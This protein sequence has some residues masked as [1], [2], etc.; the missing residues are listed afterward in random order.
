MNPRI[1]SAC[2]TV[3]GAVWAVAATPASAKATARRLL[4]RDGER[5]RRWRCVYWPPFPP[6]PTPS[7]HPHPP[8]HP[9]PPIPHPSQPP[10]GSVTHLDLDPAE[11]VA[12]ST[13]EAHSVGALAREVRGAWRPSEFI[14][15][16][17]SCGPALIWRSPRSPARIQG[18]GTAERTLS[19]SSRCWGWPHAMG[20]GI[21][22]KRTRLRRRAAAAA[23][24]APLATPLPSRLGPASLRSSATSWKPRCWSS[25]LASP[26]SS[27]LHCVSPSVASGSECRPPIRPTLMS[28]K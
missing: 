4:R 8:S 6:S 20:A 3:Q 2:S 17:S 16:L 27:S 23:Q 15:R 25:A 19:C 18:S 12:R 1:Q 24:S 21:S 10:N 13:R 7:S 5:R 28:A 14:H 9:L 26:R 11:C 22:S